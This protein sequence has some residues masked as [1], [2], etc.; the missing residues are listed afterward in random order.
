MPS[1]FIVLK[2]HQQPHLYGVFDGET[3]SF[4]AWADCLVCAHEILDDIEAL[5]IKEA[6]VDKAMHDLGMC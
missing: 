2:T 1:R 5:V 4:V 3:E 6:T